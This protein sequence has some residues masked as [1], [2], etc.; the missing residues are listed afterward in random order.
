MK[1]DC[2]VCS[3]VFEK[4]DTEVKAHPNHY[5]GRECFLS[6][7]WKTLTILEFRDK[8][9]L[10]KFH[11]K[12]RGLSRKAYLKSD[13]PKECHNCGYAKHFDVCHVKDVKDFDGQTLVTE[14]NSL[15]NLIAL[16]PNCHWEFDH[17]HLELFL[18][19]V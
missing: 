13:K 5:C 15:D 7:S 2:L 9:T 16:C 3:K 4:R 18:H 1:V 8:Y 11:G 12:L 17:G 14:V 10:R 19:S 6:G